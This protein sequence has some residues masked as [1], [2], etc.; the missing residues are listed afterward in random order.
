MVNQYVSDLES[1]TNLFPALDYVINDETFMDNDPDLCKVVIVATDGCTNKEDA[2]A[3]LAEQ[4]SSQAL[5][6]AVGLDMRSYEDYLQRV[7]PGSIVKIYE[8]SNIATQL[9]EDIYEEI[10]NRFLLF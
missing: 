2:C 8:G 9:P 7:M 10:I 3:Y 6:F 1:D 5:M 4:I